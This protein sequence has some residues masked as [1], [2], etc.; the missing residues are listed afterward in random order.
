MRR[1]EL[2]SIVEGGAVVVIG[3]S[4]LILLPSQI[5]T[6]PGLQIAVSPGIV[7]MLAG[8][9]LIIAGSGLVLQSSL[10]SVT[11]DPIDL[12]RTVIIRIVT[13]VLL[14]IAYT[15]LF[16]W[17]GFLV[18]SAVFVGFFTYFFGARSWQKIVLLVVLTP[19]GVWLFFEKL[20]RIP[21]PHGLLY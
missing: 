10:T 12:D 14:L 20:F 15:I 9:G 11:S 3:S 13:T 21:L 7:P 1:P 5:A 8:I 4:I 16:P 6:L 2:R 18:T 19:I 17:L